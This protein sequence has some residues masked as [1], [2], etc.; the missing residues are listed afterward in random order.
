M[1]GCPPAKRA[2][3]QK[4]FKELDKDGS[5]SLDMQELSALLKKGNP[6]MQ[7]SEIEALYGACDR[8]GDGVI[9]FDEFLDYI[10]S[11]DR[12][13]H[14]ND[15]AAGGRHAR[16][17]GERNVGNDE[18]ETPEGWA[19]C[20]SVFE[21]YAGQGGG[22]DNKEFAKLCKDNK[23]VGG[24]FQK[25]DV[26]LIFTKVVTKGKR[27]LDFEQFKN[28]I[29]HI[30]AKKS[31][32]NAEVMAVVGASGGPVMHATKLIGSRF[33]DDKSTF[34]GAAAH[35][36]AFEGTD[37]THGGDRHAAQ[38]AAAE[39]KLNR[40][41]EEEGDWGDCESI[42]KAFAGPGG[43][44]DGREFIKMCDDCG[45]LG[46]G[47]T[48]QDV[49]IVFA[50]AAH[51]GKKFGFEGFK[52][53]VAKI[54]DKKKKAV[55]EIQDKIAASSGPRL[56]GATKTEAVR[57]YD[58]KSTYT[59]AAGA[60][61]DREDDR[62]AGRHDAEQARLAE[63][64]NGTDDEHPWE[65]ALATFNN[66]GGANGIDSREFLKLAVDCKLFD[67]KF[68]KE[69][70]DIVFTKAVGKGNR[71]LDENSFKKAVRMM[72]FKKECRV[73]QVQ[74]VLAQHKGGPELHG[75]EA[76]YSRFHDDKETYTGMHLGK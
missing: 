22:L 19:A 66:Y 14:S 33:Y 29:R 68:R 37:A 42:F 3:L 1:A 52:V 10:Y 41:H 27:Q 62:G 13:A 30:A 60:V 56:T 71:K 70:M 8:N 4:K 36:S 51:G 40:Q 75:T 24:G 9:D 69:D 17:A 21:S 58:D 20:Q 74:T 45:L 57:F 53:A 49:D 26:D 61:F 16:L 76:E 39:G 54:A 15:R 65:E 64:E 12:S 2:Q 50:S 25:H 31:Q 34:T 44:L 72:A 11:Q 55:Y 73:D 7:N 43:E 23:L 48:K 38:L 47:L 35:N 67:S 59:G 46:G 32:S 6:G 5:N 28:A 63:I 18:T